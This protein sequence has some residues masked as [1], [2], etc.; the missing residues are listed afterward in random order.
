[1]MES[2]YFNNGNFVECSYFV[3]GNF[4]VLKWEF[5]VALGSCG[6]LVHYVNVM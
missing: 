2:G 5:L 3:G 4:A 1:M 6:S